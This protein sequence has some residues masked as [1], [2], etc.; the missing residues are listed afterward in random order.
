MPMYSHTENIKCNVNMVP[1][2]NEM[3]FFD[4]ANVIDEL[5]NTKREY[6]YSFVGAISSR[7]LGQ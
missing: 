1:L 5:R 3:Y 2:L 4:D 7:A 6:D